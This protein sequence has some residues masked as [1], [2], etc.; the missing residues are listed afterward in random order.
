MITSSSNAPLYPM[1]G[2]FG[3]TYNP[4]IDENEQEFLQTPTLFL[5]VIESAVHLL[6]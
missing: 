6:N 3:F 4:L 5:F 1:L 2:V